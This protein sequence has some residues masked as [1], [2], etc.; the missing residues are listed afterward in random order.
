MFE[1]VG[2]KNYRVYMQ[3][4]REL[5][6]SGGL[7]LLHTIGARDVHRAPDPWID[8]YIFPNGILPSV[9]EI[10][11][12]IEGIFVLEDWHNFGADYDK[13]LLAWFENFDKH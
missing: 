3:K 5:L 11:T 12:A 10:G 1:H 6:K 13:T 2:Q 4:A 9:A 8:K 7:F